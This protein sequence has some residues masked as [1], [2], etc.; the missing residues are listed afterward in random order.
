MKLFKAQCYALHAGRIDK[1]FAFASP[2]NRANTGPLPRF[3]HMISAGYPVMLRYKE[4]ALK[5][6]TL[7]GHGFGDAIFSHE[8]LL[9]DVDDS[10]HGFVWALEAVYP[11]LPAVDATPDDKCWMTCAVYPMDNASIDFAQFQRIEMPPWAD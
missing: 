8:V 11:P 5:P 1:C 7:G 10:I 9:R 6:G 4:V 3:K 2:S